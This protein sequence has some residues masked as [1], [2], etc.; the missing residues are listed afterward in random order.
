MEA[1]ESAGRLIRICGRARRPA[2][3]LERCCWPQLQA[4][5]LQKSK[6]EK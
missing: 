5:H 4:V 3:D 6:W 1:V 2:G